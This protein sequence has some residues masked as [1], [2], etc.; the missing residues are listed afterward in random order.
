MYRKMGRIGTI[1]KSKC[2]YFKK[3][4]EYWFSE[5]NKRGAALRSFIIFFF[6]LNWIGNK[7]V[8]R[9]RG[10]RSDSTHEWG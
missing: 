4:R 7:K 3:Y 8:Y 6:G 2:E 9:I 10:H 1:L 5:K